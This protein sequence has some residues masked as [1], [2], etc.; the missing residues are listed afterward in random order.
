M[1]KHQTRTVKAQGRVNGPAARKSIEN[2]LEHLRRLR[3]PW[4]E[5]CLLAERSHEPD[6]FQRSSQQKELTELPSND[7]E[8]L[9][10]LRR[11]QDNLIR[12]LAVSWKQH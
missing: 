5:Q 11:M 7:P 3:D 6:R 8:A 10:V 12:H 1:V 2:V 4:L 9:N